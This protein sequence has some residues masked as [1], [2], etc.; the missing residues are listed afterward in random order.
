MGKIIGLGTSA[1]VGI[2]CVVAIIGAICVCRWKR[3]RSRHRMKVFEMPQACAVQAYAAAA[4]PQII[5]IATGEKG[6]KKTY[7][8]VTLDGMVRDGA[9]IGKT[10]FV[11]TDSHCTPTL[12]ALKS[13]TPSRSFVLKSATPSTNLSLMVNTSKSDHNVGRSLTP[14][15]LTPPPPGCKPKKKS[16]VTSGFINDVPDESD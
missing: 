10:S 3:A 14:T 5:P 4:E 15:G 6:S 12:K 2:C 16:F 1:V 7:K 13:G 9:N 11:L 8:K